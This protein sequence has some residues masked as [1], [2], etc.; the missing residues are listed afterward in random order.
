M[1][2]GENYYEGQGFRFKK[3]EFIGELDAE[4]DLNYLSECFTYTDDYSILTDIETPQRII[5]GRTGSGKSAIIQNLKSEKENVIEILPENLSLNFIANSDLIVKLESLGIKLDL[6]Y[7]L[8]WRHVFTVELLQKKYNLVNEEK[9][10]SWLSNLFPI[11]NKKDQSKERAL[12]Y[13]KDWGDKFWCETEYRVKE[14]TQRLENEISDKLGSDLKYLNASTSESNKSINEQ[15]VEVLHKAQRIVNDVQIKALSDVLDFLA[16]DVFNDDQ[17]HY[18]I[19][20][21]KLDE[22]WIDSDLRYRLIRALIETVKSFKKVKN[23]KIIIALR[24]DLIKLVFDKTRDNT[25]QEEKYL[26]LILNLKWDKASLLTLL[27]KRVNKLLRKL[28]TQTTLGLKDVFP[29]RVDNI[30][31]DDYLLTRTLYRP[32]DGIAFVNECI[33]KADGNKINLNI[34]KQAEIEYSALRVNALADEWVAHYPKMRYYLTLLEKMPSQFKLTSFKKEVIE[35][36]SIEN[37]EFTQNTSDPVFK[38][39]YN[40]MDKGTSHHLVVIELVKAFYDMGI[41]GIK[42]DSFNSIQWSY[43][44]DRLPS[45]GQIKPNSTVYIH[46][47]FW[48][49]LGTTQDK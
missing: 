11:L 20:I 18:Y 30:E 13:L 15:K 34:I 19:V 31:F 22:N 43:V 4:S 28:Y 1:K 41:L 32:R 27:N 48:A 14:I 38:A 5:V 45:S 26:S 9:T 25:F 46:P 39:A 2:Q 21:D 49:R 12:S 7:A 29:P 8:L 16:E 3:G 24:L 36:F 33:K 44:D 35:A 42:T 37:L 40:F 6:F 47:M 10:K 23:V 17:N